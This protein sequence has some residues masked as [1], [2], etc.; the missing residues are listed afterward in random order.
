M[1]QLELL[2]TMAKAGFTFGKDTAGTYLTHNELFESLNK[3]T[4]ALWGDRVFYSFHLNESM[5]HITLT[6]DG[7]EDMHRVWLEDDELN[8]DRIIAAVIH[9]YTWVP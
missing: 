6:I 1:T 4:V 3:W 8:L 9:M 2:Q 7:F 5:P